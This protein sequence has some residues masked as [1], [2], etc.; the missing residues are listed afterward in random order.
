[1]SY[2]EP[3]ANFYREAANL[4]ILQRGNPIAICDKTALKLGHPLGSI[5][6]TITVV[7]AADD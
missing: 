4:H 7:V 5:L 2:L 6:G 3:T 1:M